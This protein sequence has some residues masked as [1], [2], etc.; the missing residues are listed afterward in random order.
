MLTTTNAN[1]TNL[2][3]SQQLPPRTYVPPPAPGTGRYTSSSTSHQ[4]GLFTYSIFDPES[5]TR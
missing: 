1:K 5:D 4:T 2:L 3:Q